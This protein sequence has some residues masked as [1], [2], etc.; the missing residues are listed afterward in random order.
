MLGEQL[1][2][3]SRDDRATANLD[4]IDHAFGDQ[5]INL[6]RAETGIVA[7]L[8]DRPT[9]LISGFHNQLH[10]YPPHGGGLRWRDGEP[11]GPNLYSITSVTSVGT[12]VTRLL[13]FPK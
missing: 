3:R 12:S 5:F 8:G 4:V 11:D 7:V 2:W 10:H 1:R 6:G 9:L 13:K